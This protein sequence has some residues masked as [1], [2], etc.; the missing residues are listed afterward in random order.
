[1]RILVLPGDGIGPEI[2]SATMAVVESVNAKHGLGLVFEHDI[3]GFDSLKKHGSTFRDDLAQRFP[4]YDGV[5]LG[6]NQGADYPPAEQGGINFSAYTRT[7]YDLYANIRPAKTPPGF[8][9]K[10]GPMD[11]VIVREV[12]EGHYSDRNMY[13]GHGEVMPDPD[14]VIS[15][16]KV[17]RH[18]CERVCRRAFEIAMTR[19][20]RLTVVHKA[21]VLR[22]G[23]GMFLESARKVAAEFPEVKVDDVLVDAMCAH[24]VRSPD[25]FDVV[26]TGNLYGDLLSDLASEL[27]GSLGLSGAIMAGDDLCAAQA[28]H[29]AAPDIAGQNRANP[30]SLMLSVAMLM[31]WLGTRHA[32]QDLG[33][34]GASIRDAVY[35]TIAEPTTRTADL[36]GSLGTDAFGAAV[37]S[38]LNG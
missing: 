1:M 29:G 3:V 17:T 33:R 15:L 38:K 28:Q 9:N 6:P 2:T 27:S 25:R 31:E 35:A 4:T 10:V 14:M 16:R 24:L 8:A 23:D 36:G 18:A 34:A 37:T 20:K 30:T 5:I 13:Q 26:V 22:L 7:K 11:L 12:T 19:K 32:R 21:N